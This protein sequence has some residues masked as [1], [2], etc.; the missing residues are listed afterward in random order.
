LGV[1]DLMPCMCA[2]RWWPQ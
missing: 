1:S 2:S